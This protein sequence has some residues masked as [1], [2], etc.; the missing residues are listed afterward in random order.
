[1]F[2]LMK[3]GPIMV[4][5]ILFSFAA[6]RYSLHIPDAVSKDCSLSVYYAFNQALYDVPLR[7]AVGEHHSNVSAGG[8]KAV[9]FS[10]AESQRCSIDKNFIP[11][12]RHSTDM[13]IGFGRTDIIFPFHSFT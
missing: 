7:S 12:K 8:Y 3:L 2:S 1:M 5:L 4:L 9:E 13:D 10:N 6:S 11:Y